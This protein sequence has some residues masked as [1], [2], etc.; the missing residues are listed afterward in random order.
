MPRIAWVGRRAGRY[1]LAAVW[2][3]ALVVP[4]RVSAQATASRELV[5]AGANALLGGFTS[6]V[7]SWVRG[8]SFLEGLGAGALGGSVQYVGK[9]VS[10]SALPGAGLAGGVVG[11]VGSSMVRNGAAGRGWLDRLIIP[12][13]PVMVDWRTAADSGGVTARLHLGRAIFL[14]RLI[15]DDDLEL[16]V[17]ETLSAGA[18][19]FGA[20]GRVIEGESGRGIGGVE[21]WGTIALSDGNLMPTIDFGRLLAHERVHLVQDAFLNIAWA[22]PVEDWLLER[23]PYGGVVG[24]YVDVGG[25]YMVIAGLM[26]LALPYESRPWEDEAAYLE[27]GW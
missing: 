12:V 8:G 2:V 22:D 15:V 17:A 27:S 5:I 20:R 25:I 1:A 7:V 18:P 19:V 6:G 4:E 13:G 11:A 24:R 3:A 14:G 23:I 26:I 16:N 10:T 21:L 9:R